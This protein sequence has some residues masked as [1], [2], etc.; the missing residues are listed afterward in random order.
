MQHLKSLLFRGYLGEDT[1]ETYWGDNRTS[2][3]VAKSEPD[4]LKSATKHIKLR[5]MDVNDIADQL[6]FVPTWLQR[7]DATTKSSCP[8]AHR[9]ML[10]VAPDPKEIL[11][12]MKKVD[13]PT[14][15]VFIW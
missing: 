6:E 2:I 12:R 11:K 14:F 1:T 13:D 5:M 7:A 9:D 15:F 8:Q 4:A 10:F 3:T